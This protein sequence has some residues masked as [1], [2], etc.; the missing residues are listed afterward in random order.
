MPRVTNKACLWMKVR[1]NIFLHDFTD[2]ERS[3]KS[4]NSLFWCYHVVLFKKLVFF[5]SPLN[6]RKTFQ[7]QFLIRC[8]IDLITNVLNHCVQC[9]RHFNCIWP[10]LTTSFR[11]LWFWISVFS[12]V[13][14][15]SLTASFMLRCTVY[16][17]CVWRMLLV[18]SCSTPLMLGLFITIFIILAHVL[19]IC[20][21]YSCVKVSH[22]ILHI[23]ACVIFAKL[24]I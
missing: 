2:S 4:R 24:Q 6:M 12:R 16:L 5:T 19:F 8:P 1:S 7:F 14:Q 18:L 9:K 13:S 15:K 21:I 11:F 22:L 3:L 20:A 23:C 10:N 17:Q